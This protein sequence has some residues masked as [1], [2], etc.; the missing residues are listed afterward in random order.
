MSELSG[1]SLSRVVP[2]HVRTIRFNWCKRDFMVFG[3]FKAARLRRRTSLNG[4]ENCFWCKKQFTDEDMMALAQ[5]E[6]G[7][8]TV[9]C[10]CCAE[11]IQ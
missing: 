5:P 2:K 6:K 8:N 4:F 7:A 3:T 11:A 1:G 10:Q 9:L